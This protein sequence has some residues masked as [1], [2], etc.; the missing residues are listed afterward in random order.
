MK[1]AIIIC[2][3]A[4][5]SFQ[6]AFGQTEGVITYNETIKMDIQFEG[7]DE[8]MKDMLPES[9]TFINDLI[10]N[11]S[12][13]IYQLAKDGGADD[14]EL[15][16]DDGSFKIKFATS[17]VE[18]ILY[19]NTAEKTKIHQKGLMGKPFLVSSEL[20]KHKWKITNEKVKYLDYECQK[21]TIED[22]DD[23]IV[24]WF[25][26]QIPVQIGPGKY[27]GLPGA[28]LLLSVNEDKVAYKATSVNLETL[29][30]G[31]IVKPKKGKKV[32]EE[33]YEEIR[34]QKE[35]EMMEMYGD[36]AVKIRN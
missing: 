34:I 29:E 25:T 27:H 7:M 12:E 15:T 1:K 32:S 11:K 22:G 28:I 14:L 9:Q 23:F 4:V 17:D 19:K 3:L 20:A 36:G 18:E 31:A 5:L 10:F 16:S 6:Y 24:A 30:D 21:A 33:K 2:L 26:S 13:S 35:K 8:S